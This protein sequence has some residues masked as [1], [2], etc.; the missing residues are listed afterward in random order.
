MNIATLGALQV[1][2]ALIT[3][4]KH[5]TQDVMARDQEGTPCH[6]SDPKAY[7]FCVL[8]AWQRATGFYDV[9]KSYSTLRGLCPF[10]LLTSDFKGHKAV[11]KALDKTIK[12]AEKDWDNTVG[13]T[14]AAL[15]I[16]PQGVSDQM[17]HYTNVS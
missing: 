11:L 14:I 13:A 12:K 16:S 2:R 15:K 3:D 7:S 8:G 17:K 9:N 6:A 10:I 5:F 1:T 4:P